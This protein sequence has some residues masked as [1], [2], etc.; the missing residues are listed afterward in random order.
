MSAL[1]ING[2][3]GGAL[4]GFG[5]VAEFAHLPALLAHPNLTLHS[6]V[7]PDARRRRHA[8][9]LLGDSIR[10]YATMTELLCS[11]RPTFVDVA[12]PP[13][14][15]AAVIEQ[16]AA[17]GAHLLVEKPLAFNSRDLQRIEDAVDRAG[18]ALMTVHNWHN[19]PVFRA[20]R[21]AIDGGEIGKARDVEVRME[22]S[23]PAGG[24]NSWRLRSE[25]AGG[26]ILID[27]GWHQIYLAL[28]LLGQTPR[29]VSATVETRRWTD[30]DVEDTVACRVG[31]D[32][33][34]TLRLKLTWAARERSSRVRVRGETATLVI[35][36][37]RLSLEQRDGSRQCLPVEA[38]GAD[39]SYH[40]A[41]FPPIL[42][43]FAAA[44]EQ[45]EKAREN[46]EEAAAC[47]AVIE[48]AYLSASRGGVETVVDS[49]G[50]DAQ[51]DAS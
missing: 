41:W 31:F 38:D 49:R 37:G 25:L 42:D 6:I 28:A 27:H 35:E 30:A 43:A 8:R 48:S 21:R 40:A 32:D 1:A 7:D 24:P 20:A 22:R 3:R 12:A 39:D 2:D 18:V 11:E 17:H 26:G 33:A 10:T 19:A 14:A 47:C 23:Q 51:R 16:A 45:P 34:A 9:Q 29:T 5:R 50:S 44:T 46:R 4:V 36:D 13:V 15:R